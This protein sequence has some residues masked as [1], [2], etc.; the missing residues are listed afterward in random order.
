MLFKATVTD[1]GYWV[2]IHADYIEEGSHGILAKLKSGEI[3]AIIPS[4]MVIF[5]ESD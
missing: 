4:S 1:G 3:V 5:K 2:K